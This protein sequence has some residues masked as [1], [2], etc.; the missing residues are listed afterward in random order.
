LTVSAF[1]NGDLTIDGRWRCSL[2]AAARRHPQPTLFLFHIAMA[3]TSSR[4]WLDDAAAATVW[5]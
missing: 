3:I 5:G 2:L 1:G 4:L